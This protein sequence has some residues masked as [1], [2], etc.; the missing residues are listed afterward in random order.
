MGATKSQGSILKIEDYSARGAAKTITGIT[1]AS[2][3]VVTAVAHGYNNGDIVLISGVVGMVEVNDR[4][5][6]VAN[7]STDTFELEGVLG[8]SYTAY[9]SGG[10]AYKL[11]LLEVG[12][13]ANFSGFDGQSNEIDV[14]H[15]R[16][17]AKEYLIGL[18]DFGNAQFTVQMDNADTGQDELRSAK[19]LAVG[20]GFS[21]QLSDG[22]IATFLA[23][24]R[25]FTIDL[26]GPDNAVQ[27]QISL[28]IS[29]E[30]AWFV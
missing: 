29:G 20:H 16:S 3:P 14:T 23:L 1:A 30:P 7:K 9:S 27:S 26:G 11:T 4:V 10:S 15:L 13:V 8:T 17:T 28:R 2:P 6:Q 25:Q 18:Q 22:T 24:V 21:L 12:R 19:G 5:F